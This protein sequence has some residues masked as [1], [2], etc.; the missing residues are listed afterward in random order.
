M[1]FLRKH[2]VGF[3]LGAL[4]ILI[5]AEVCPVFSIGF[6]RLAVCPEF[7]ADGVGGYRA[8][9]LFLRLR[10]SFSPE[11]SFVAL[12]HVGN[13][14]AQAYAL[15]GLYEIRSDRFQKLRDAYRS[16]AGTV[17]LRVGSSTI[18]VP[19]HDLSYVFEDHTYL[20]KNAEE[21]ANKPLQGTEG[22]VPSSSPEPEALRP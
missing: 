8:E 19:M 18:E 10:H 11:C 14:Q 15:Y 2:F 9:R 1:T 7:A 21:G 22:K 3:L 13:R 6:W 20:T 17:L 4:S 16:K 12:Y 5:L